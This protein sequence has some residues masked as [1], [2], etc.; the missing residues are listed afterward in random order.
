LKLTN[1]HTTLIDAV[2]LLDMF[3]LNLRS[4]W[5]F[6]IRWPEVEALRRKKSKT[7]AEKGEEQRLRERGAAILY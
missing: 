4:L 2:A 5:W 6:T 3:S 1:Y 7:A